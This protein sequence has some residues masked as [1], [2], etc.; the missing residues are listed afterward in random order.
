[1]PTPDEIADAAAAAASDG[2]QSAS[3]DGEAATQLSPMTQ[4]D[5]ADRLRGRTALDVPNPNGG[6]ETGW[7]FL[8]PAR[9][10]NRGDP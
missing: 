3:L 5:V 1:M 6:A 7:N 2:I 10:L 8:R 9:G 4:L